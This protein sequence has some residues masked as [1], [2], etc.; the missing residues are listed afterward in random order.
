[1]LYQVMLEFIVV[2][3]AIQQMAWGGESKIKLDLPMLIDACFAAGAAMISFGAVL[4]RTTPAQITWLLALQV[5]FPMRASHWR[6]LPLLQ[7]GTHVDALTV[8]AG[9]SAYY[10]SDLFCFENL[11]C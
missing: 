5:R 10:W 2:G 1:M 4:G 6:G 3:G 9:S 7:G 8:D 11:F